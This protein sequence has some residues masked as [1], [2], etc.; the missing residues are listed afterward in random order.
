MIGSDAAPAAPPAGRGWRRAETAALGG[1]EEI[2]G[3]KRKLWG[4]QWK[5]IGV[6]AQS[7][8]PAS[9]NKALTGQALLEGLGQ[10]LQEEGKGSG[11]LRPFG[12][13]PRPFAL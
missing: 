10:S 13:K 1:G 3:E 4:R 9:H 6:R 5:Q 2:W 11:E 7:Q 12:L 8:G